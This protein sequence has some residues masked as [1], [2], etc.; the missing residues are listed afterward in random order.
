MHTFGGKIW[1]TV[2]KQGGRLTNENGQEAAFF[3]DGTQE[4]EMIVQI[5]LG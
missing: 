4:F 2:A 3:L 5:F 1:R